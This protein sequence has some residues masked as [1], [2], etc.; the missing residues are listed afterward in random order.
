MFRNKWKN[1][2][3]IYINNVNVSVCYLTYFCKLIAIKFN[4]KVNP[5]AFKIILQYLYTGR[6]ET[7]LD[8]I[9]DVKPLVKQCKLNRLMEQIDDAVKKI[10]SFGENQRL[11]IWSLYIL[12][13]IYFEI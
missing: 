4:V 6:L 12:L 7:R 8:L 5:C 9:D 3:I 11:K 2:K 13:K 10:E 1:R